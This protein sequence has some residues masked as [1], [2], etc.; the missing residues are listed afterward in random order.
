MNAPL[1]VRFNSH[2]PRLWLTLWSCTFHS[3]KINFALLLFPSSLDAAGPYKLLGWELGCALW[4][5]WPKHIAKNYLIGILGYIWVSGVVFV[6]IENTG[7]EASCTP[8]KNWEYLGLTFEESFNMF[9]GNKMWLLAGVSLTQPEEG[10]FYLVGV[11]LGSGKAVPGQHEPGVGP[12]R[13]AG[14]VGSFSFTH[15]FVG[16]G[17]LSRLF[18]SPPPVHIPASSLSWETLFRRP[19]YWTP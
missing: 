16:V 8:W 9:P 11:L 18:I 6:I 4:Y 15:S 3:I 19:E 12:G 1:F 14:Q 2:Y 7:I 13:P 10:N 17:P 5:I